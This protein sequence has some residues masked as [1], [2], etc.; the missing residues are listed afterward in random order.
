M[1]SGFLFE[2]FSAFLTQVYSYEVFVGNKLTFKL[3][4]RSGKVSEWS[5][6]HIPFIT[7]C[8][9]DLRFTPIFHLQSQFL[10]SICSFI[11]TQIIG[12]SVTCRG[13]I[14]IQWEISTSTL[15]LSLN[16]YFTS[17]SFFLLSTFIIIFVA[18][19]CKRIYTH[20]RLRF[21]IKIFI[22]FYFKRISCYMRF[23]YRCAR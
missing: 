16:L 12:N 1:D 4:G 5:I 3:R 14:L 15:V 23:P 9:V 18:T 19:I 7:L 8:L 2:R 17:T 20:N 13:A 6:L 21:S 11:L 22:F 10:Q